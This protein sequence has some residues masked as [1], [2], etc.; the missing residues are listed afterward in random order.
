MSSSLLLFR[1][2][3]VKGPHRHVQEYLTGGLSEKLATSQLR[4]IVVLD[5]F[6]RRYHR[7]AL[8]ALGQC[9]AMNGL[10]SLVDDRTLASLLRER[11]Y[12]LI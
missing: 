1:G 7:Q 9:R 10:K 3:A 2:V 4:L 8:N 6:Y 12:E 11:A 5:G